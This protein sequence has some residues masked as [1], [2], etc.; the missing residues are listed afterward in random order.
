MS[1]RISLFRTEGAGRASALHLLLY[2]LISSF[3]LWIAAP[4]HADSAVNT[5]T[6]G[7]QNVPSIATDGQGRFIVVWQSEG[8]DGDEL[9]V[10]G[11]RLD[12]QGNPIGD[13]FQV[14]TYTTGSQGAPEVAADT[15]GNFIVVWNGEAGGGRSDIL[16]QRFDASGATVGGEIQLNEDTSSDQSGAA[17]ALADDGSFLAIW[18]NVERLVTRGFDDQSIPTAGDFELARNDPTYPDYG[19]TSFFR[20]GA[21]A[22]SNGNFVVAWHQSYSSTYGYAY[23]DTVHGAVFD[24]LGNLNDRVNISSSAPAEQHRGAHLAPTADGGFV[25]VWGGYTY[26]AVY[27][28]ILGRRFSAE[29]V[30]QGDFFEVVPE[31]VAAP[32][33]TDVTA[34][35]SDRFLVVWTD[36]EVEGRFVSTDGTP[37]GEEFRINSRTAGND[38]GPVVASNDDGPL[39]VWSKDVMGTETRSDLFSAKT[40]LFFG[41]GFE[42][43]DTSAWTTTVS[44]F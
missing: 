1:Y 2:L 21:E 20:R 6:T 10:F 40:Q 33:P 36:P 42:S 11:R 27:S 12:A 25:T 9:G 30:P 23:A 37:L 15:T 18:S 24:D 31:D 17:V 38:F 44:G 32:S 3:W 22:L 7:F 8:Q 34:V 16:A 39:V 14:N 19:T 43:G 26:Y 13:E 5:Y 35:G 4:G 28:Q 41:D 29:G